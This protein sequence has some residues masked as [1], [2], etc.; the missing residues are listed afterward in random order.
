M[1]GEHTKI[2]DLNGKMATPSMIDA[3]THPE[4]VAADTCINIKWSYDIDS[5]VAECKEYIEDHKQNYY[6]SRYYPSDIL[7]ENP[8]V[9]TLTS[10]MLEDLG[11]VPVRLYDFSDHIWWFN[12]KAM[13]LMGIDKNT[14]QCTGAGKIC[15]YGDFSGCGFARRY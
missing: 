3:H 13:K 7:S 9:K 12:N 14:P 2:Q 15:R 1:K 11:D 6:E 8:G 5:I 4:A 10:D